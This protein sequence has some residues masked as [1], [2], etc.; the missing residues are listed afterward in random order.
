MNSL[1][2]LCR[3][4]LVNVAFIEVVLSIKFR[5]NLATIVISLF[6]CLNKNCLFVL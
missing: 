6:V 5:L 2:R 1:K 4:M 3:K